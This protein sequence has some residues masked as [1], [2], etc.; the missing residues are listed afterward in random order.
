[1][2][3]RTARNRKANGT[4]PVTPPAA[5]GSVERPE[6]KRR[7]GR[8][9]SA[10]VAVLS[11]PAL[12][13]DAPSRSETQLPGG[14]ERTTVRSVG[15]D[16]GS[17]EVS[18]CEVSQGEVVARRT[19]TGGLKGLQDVLGPGAPQ[20]VVA[21]EACREAWHVHDQLVRAGHRV[22]LVD[23]T[24][25]RRMGIGQHRRKNDRIDAEVLARAVEDGRIPRAHVLSP[26]R[27]LL[28]EKLATR[29]ALVEARAQL[30]VTIRGIVR[31]RGEA[32]PSCDTEH[33]VA[34]VR[35]AV[36]EPETR[37]VIGPLVNVV[38]SLHGELSVVEAE[39]ERLAATEPAISQLTT[40]PG[41]GLVVAAAFVSVI[42]EAH[43][44][45]DAHQ[46][47][48]YLG[49]VPSE[50]TSGGRRR[51]GAITKC[52]NPYVRALLVQSAW[53]I[54]RG[55]KNDPLRAWAQALSK[56]R[57]KR[58]AV[59]ALARRLA[60]VLWAMWRHGQVY[61]PELVGKASARGLA[62]AAAS[63]E[64]TARAIQTI[65]AKTHRR[66]QI[67]NARRPEETPTN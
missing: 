44:F 36:L 19:T 57:D 35:G 49:L 24:R 4:A 41:V 65:A 26:E 46:V 61:D 7:A 18:F 3:R 25:A 51:V 14:K 30:V 6:G 29:R 15:I 52:G 64:A 23:T 63:T 67:M 13:D 33:L 62:R 8:R 55:R 50:D 21:I 42:D 59:V 16:W 11:P 53:C 60:G 12:A 20:A 2:T 39:L 27:R 1:M 10:K 66:A 43:R 45:R 28:R 48:S 31:A 5:S 34:K 32:L 38:A 54:L 56:R 9:S 17:R 58:I 40:A 47:E 37:A 22:L